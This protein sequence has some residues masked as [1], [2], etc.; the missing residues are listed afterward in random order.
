MSPEPGSLYASLGA[1]SFE[2]HRSADPAACHLLQVWQLR[3]EDW[4]LVIWEM[5]GF[6]LAGAKD[7]A[8]RLADER[9]PVIIAG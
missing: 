4:P 5:D 7:K 1:Y 2:I 9:V 8:E 3:P 6:T